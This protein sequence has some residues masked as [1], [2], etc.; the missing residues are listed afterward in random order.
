MATKIGSLIEGA[1]PGPQ[2]ALL[3]WLVYAATVAEG[4]E[5]QKAEKYAKG[6]S[7][8]LS[9]RLLR[10]PREFVKDNLLHGVA[11][12]G[13]DIAGFSIPKENASNR[14]AVTGYLFGSTLTSEQATTLLKK[15]LNALVAENSGINLSHP[16][17]DDVNSLARALLPTVNELFERAAQERIDAQVRSIREL[18]AKPE[19]QWRIRKGE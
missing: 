17:L 19:W 6:F 18:E 16:T 10:L 3:L 9:A 14:G 1:L 7:Q 2:D 15:G 5:E 8:G 4:L 13:N 11:R 12:Y